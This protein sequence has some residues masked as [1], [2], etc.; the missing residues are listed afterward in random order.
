MDASPDTFF[1]RRHHA[2]FVLFQP[3]GGSGVSGGSHG[4]ASAVR[5]RLT[6]N[7]GGVAGSPIGG[8]STFPALTRDSPS[9]PP[10]SSAVVAAGSAT[11]SSP[12]AISPAS[13]RSS[14]RSR[15]PS[16]VLAS[17]ALG[18]SLSGGLGQPSTGLTLHGLA[19]KAKN[20][21]R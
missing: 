9:S 19:D 16:L 8:N 4:H 21:P 10:P 6:S 20:L 1:L 18:G 2:Q 11:P 15:P 14:S 5:A 7:L 17:S 13:S 12:T 3:L